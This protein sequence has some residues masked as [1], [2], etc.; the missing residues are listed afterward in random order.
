MKRVEAPAGYRLGP[1]LTTWFC[2]PKTGRKRLRDSAAAM[3]LASH[4]CLIRNKFGKSETFCNKAE[5]KQ[6][7]VAHS[8]GRPIVGFDASDSHRTGAVAFQH[9]GST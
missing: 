6:L 2:L 4:M 3:N 1:K 5:I 8:K 9:A 7:R